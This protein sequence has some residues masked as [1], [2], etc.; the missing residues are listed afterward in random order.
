MRWISGARRSDACACSACCVAFR[1]YWARQLVASAA[2]IANDFAFYGNKLQQGVFL[3]LLFPTVRR[4]RSCC[5]LARA[6]P[7]GWRWEAFAH[8]QRAALA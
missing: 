8:G 3:G 5:L 2:W 1:R 7:C 4:R 6:W